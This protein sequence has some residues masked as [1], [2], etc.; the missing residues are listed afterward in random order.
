MILNA[1]ERAR[2]AQAVA[3]ILGHMRRCRLKLADLIDSGGDDLESSN[4][5]R[6]EKARRVE[7]TWSHMA[8]RGIKFA[9]LE[10]P[11]G[12]NTHEVG[13]SSTWRGW[14]FRSP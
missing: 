6:A 3:E 8:R 7:R 12:P 4:P 2:H 14:V 1:A 11:P 13:T 9:D 5:T 10:R